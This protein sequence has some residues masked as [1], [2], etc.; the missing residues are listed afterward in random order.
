MAV[1]WIRVHRACQRFCALGRETPTQGETDLRALADVVLVEDRTGLV[2]VTDVLERLGRVAPCLAEENLVTAGVLEAEKGESEG[3][4]GWFD[5]SQCVPQEP[6]R[7]C[8]GA[9][10]TSS[11]NLLMA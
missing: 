2:G 1:P 7:A 5:E 6:R 10:L 11:R 4:A 8:Q 3:R 9:A